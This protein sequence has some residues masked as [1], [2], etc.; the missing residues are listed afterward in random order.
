MFQTKISA[1]TLVCCSLSLLMRR[2]KQFRICKNAFTR[3]FFAN[4]LPS[5]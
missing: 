3:H 4:R 2:R 5:P 1:Q